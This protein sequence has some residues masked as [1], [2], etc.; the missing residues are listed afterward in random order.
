MKKEFDGNL[1]D[2]IK[3]EAEALASYEKLRDS[4]ANE[5]DPDPESIYCINPCIS[6]TKEHEI[7]KRTHVCITFSPGASSFLLEFKQHM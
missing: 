6:L 7:Q 4:S 2:A 3:T 5:R 1:A